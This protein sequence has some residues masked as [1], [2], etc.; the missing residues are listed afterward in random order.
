MSARPEP[1]QPPLAQSSVN[2]DG[3]QGRQTCA[4]G[5]E[6][7]PSTELPPIQSHSDKFASA[8]NNTT[9]PSLSSV[10]GGPPPP[11]PP[12]H[13]RQPEPIKH[14]PS[15]NP[16]TAFYAPS[17]VEPPKT[18]Q[19]R[20]G[21]VNLDDPDVRAAAEALG[22]LRADFLSSPPQR[23]TPLSGMSTNRQADQ[24]AEPLLSLITTTVPSLAGPVEKGTKLVENATSLYNQGKNMSPTVV[25]TGVEYV[26]GYL[27]PVTK[28]VG[29]VSR[30]TGM[31]GGLRWILNRRRHKTSDPDN[32]RGGNKRRKT[33]LTQKEVEAIGGLSGFMDLDQ[34]RRMSISTVDTLPAYDN[35]SSPAYTES[36][37]SANKP[38]SRPGSS[39]G[40]QQ[41]M[42]STSS[43][44][45]T[46]TAP[47]RESLRS[48]LHNLRS[49]NSYIAQRVEE[50]KRTA[51]QYDAV[52]AKD[53]D[54]QYQSTA[55][56][57]SVL[58]ARMDSLRRDIYSALKSAMDVTSMS[59]SYLPENVKAFIR[60]SFMN[61]PS[62]FPW[63]VYNDI[64][65][66]QKKGADQE[67]VMRE[68][69]NIALQFAKEGLQTMSAVT[70]LVETTLV[71]AEEW[72]DTL[73][74][75][76]TTTGSPPSIADSAFSPSTTTAHFSAVGSP[77]STV[78]PDVRMAEA[79]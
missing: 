42:V 15:L 30:K 62:R 56:D 32:D 21:S 75:K 31:E 2:G 68:R 19:P 5:S 79:K 24:T 39:S 73:Y 44:A 49:I 69:C 34:D 74:K 52:A 14:W 8:S 7:C 70:N 29:N 23:S 48:C 59:G 78:D 47:A 40:L 36:Q 64:N 10:T 28:V 55:G 41:I 25:K 35:L 18:V 65:Q 37:E 67:K 27:S 16:L 38:S 61:L 71:S 17:H 53:Q 60:T 45:V 6:R 1:L 11:L 57:R 4:P 9:L 66:G 22:E 58:M 50:L 26:E 33:K 63:Q 13:Q 12:M 77:T 46:I 72:I 51:E 54:G 76:E 43:L 20:A 3:Y